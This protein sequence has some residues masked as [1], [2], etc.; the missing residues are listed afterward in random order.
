MAREKTSPKEEDPKV[1]LYK[2]EIA[3][4][5]IEAASIEEARKIAYSKI[6]RLEKS[7]IDGSVK[8]VTRGKYSSRSDRLDEAR[9]MIEDAK[10]IVEE[11][12]GE[13]EEWRDNLPENLQ[14]SEK[15]S[16]LEECASNLESVESSLDEASSNCDS[17]E[18][19][20]MY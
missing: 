4:G 3:I 9:T 7:E 2:V 18:F 8:R 17:V 6:N 5:D 19:P 11:L 20:G 1:K 13:I 12:K 14:G 16:S 10:G 15:Y